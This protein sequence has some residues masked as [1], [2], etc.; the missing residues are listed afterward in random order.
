MITWDQIQLLAF[1]GACH[2]ASLALVTEYAKRVHKI[3]SRAQRWLPFFLAFP[4]TF[5]GLPLAM[6]MVAL[7]VGATQIESIGICA[8]GAICA[9]SGSKVAY[10]VARLLKND[11]IA[12]LQAKVRLLGG[13]KNDDDRRE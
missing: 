9:A 11:I 1:L 8:F 10:D 2:S 3:G 13:A 7:D 12:A 5:L 4:S 6:R